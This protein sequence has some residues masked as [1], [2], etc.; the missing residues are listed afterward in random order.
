LTFSGLLGALD[1]VIDLLAVHHNIGGRLDAQ[2]DGV[3]LDAEDFDDDP[4]VDDNALIRLS[5]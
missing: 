2:L 5:G 3:P 1:R 4:A